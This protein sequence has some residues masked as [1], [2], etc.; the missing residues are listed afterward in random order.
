MGKITI[1][2]AYNSVVASSWHICQLIDL[3]KVAT[4]I[5]K[6]K[7]KSNKTDK[8]CKKSAFFQ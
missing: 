7:K 2:I 5:H 8:K 4:N 6:K 3:E 1:E